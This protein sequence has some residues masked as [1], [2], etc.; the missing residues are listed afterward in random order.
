MKDKHF[1]G[2][3]APASKK[4]GEKEKKEKEHV[5]S[6]GV[7]DPHALEDDMDC[8][9]GNEA[10]EQSKNKRLAH[11]R[12]RALG[13]A[14]D[15]LAM[16]DSKRVN[17]INGEKTTGLGF[18]RN[19]EQEY[20]SLKE[21]E[22]VM[23]RNKMEIETLNEIVELRGKELELAKQQIIQQVETMKD[24]E[25]KS[26]IEKARLIALVKGQSKDLEQ[27]KNLIRIE[28]ARLAAFT[29]NIE[30]KQKKVK[31][32]E[33]AL[34]TDIV[35]LRHGLEQLSNIHDTKTL[36]SVNTVDGVVTNTN[37]EQNPVENGNG[38]KNGQDREIGQPKNKDSNP[39]NSESEKSHGIIESSNGGD[40][41]AA[42]AAA[43]TIIL[44]Y[45]KVIVDTVDQ[46]KKEQAINNLLREK[47]VLLQNNQDQ[48]HNRTH[49]Q[50]KDFSN[51][52]SPKRHITSTDTASVSTNL[53]R[54]KSHDAARGENQEGYY[55]YP[56]KDAHMIEKTNESA[57]AVYLDKK[58]DALREDIS[59]LDDHIK[60]LQDKILKASKKQALGFR[61]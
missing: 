3:H 21:R 32:G 22:S 43:E 46:L 12:Q 48:H 60:G 16:N 38:N 50:V 2:S 47:I 7:A 59:E 19:L 10:V 54:K 13:V 41:P 51:S 58:T 42:A 49:H 61:T 27:S 26:K 44:Q 56:Q 30:E 55:P 31:S 57:N 53:F 39:K 9:W 28:C 52:L 17:G 24:M 35:K 45:R 4:R 36:S 40:V 29:K 8:V 15:H 20:T 23:H 25:M 33:R 18:A 34:D 11:A 14:L 6:A 1:R 37:L 5:V